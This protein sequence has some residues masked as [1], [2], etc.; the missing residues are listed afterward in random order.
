MKLN[1]PIKTNHVTHEG[2]PARRINY[3]QQLKRTICSC[4]LWEK[5]FYE[6]GKSIVDRIRET[7]PKVDAR[8][9]SQLAIDARE[10]FKLRHVPL[11]MVREMAKLPTHK[12]YV[13]STL[14][15]VIQRADE[16]A[17]FL[18]LYWQDGK[19]PLSSQVK[20]GLACAFTKFNAYNLA[21][22]NR[23][24]AVKLRDVLFLCHAKPKDKEQEMVWKS[25]VDNTIETPDIWEVELSAGKD[26][27][28]TWERL[29]SE[30]KLGAL[31]L[32]RNLRNM[33]QA[34]VDERLIFS[35]LGQ[36][37]TERIL[38]FRFIAAARYAPQWEDK[39][40]VPM[41]K[42]LENAEKLNGKTV[43]LVDCSGS[44]E[45]NLS[46]KS[47]LTRYDA[48][49]ALAILLREICEDVIILTFNTELRRIAPRRGFA[50]RDAMGY[51]SGGTYL[52]SAVRFVNQNQYDRLIVITDE[53]SHDAVP[54]PIGKGYMINVASYKN[55]VGYGKWNHVDGFSE[56]VVNWIMEYERENND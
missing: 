46:A 43:L 41:M 52:G 30:N 15:R 1:V 25:L 13:K 2:T 8:I 5:E 55:G 44:M 10:K 16:L 38:P 22:Y 34:N 48:A 7:I 35:A 40:E 20:K 31:A 23:D 27:K 39:I 36:M 21:K 14:S 28:V 51:A 18:A 42:C 26:K 53:Q 11:L 3:E 9:V 19:C 33:Y 6:D 49:R 56:A 47:D 54:N 24:G 17:E 29:L 37:K 50:L 45:Y 32:L 12:N 4:L